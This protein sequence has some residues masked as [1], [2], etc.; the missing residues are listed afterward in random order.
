MN[1]SVEEVK[2]LGVIGVIGYNSH[3]VQR[4]IMVKSSTVPVS[5]DQLE[6]CHEIFEECAIA[7]AKEKHTKSF[8]RH[9]AY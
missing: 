2:T 1:L 4:P 5:Q 7:Y 6:E 8:I 9:W 3:K